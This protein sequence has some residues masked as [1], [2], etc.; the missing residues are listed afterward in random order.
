M[1]FRKIA[2]LIIS[3]VLVFCSADHG[4]AKEKLTLEQFLSAPFPSHL[5][6][7]KKA[8]RI[9]W[10]FLKQGELNV[11]TAAAPDFKPVNLTGFGRNEV[12]EIPSV[13]ITDDGS[14]VVYVR[15]GN[16]NREGWVTN[17]T[18]DPDGVEQAVWAIDVATKKTWKVALGRNPVISPD[19]K[20][21][22]LVK[23]NFIYKVP[24]GEPGQ[25]DKPASPKQLFKAQGQNGSPQWSPDGRK[26]A[27]VSQRED[28]NFIG[29]YDLEKHNITWMAPGVDRDS[30]PLWASDGNKV[31]FFRRPGAE[32]KEFTNPFEVPDAGI[33]IADAETG[34]GREIWKQARDEKPRYYEMRDLYVSAN[35][36]VLFTAEHDNWYH[37]F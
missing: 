34:K 15:G 9:A 35:D 28:H 6:A 22:L 7:A 13:R 32:F 8:D 31:V 36:R 33:W 30:N 18:S 11:W 16:P 1:L 29:V 24:M 12:Y 25:G 10:T 21:I 4:I 2:I 5:V 14:H 27:F 3:L 37:V 17:P 26:I 19:G 20:W 23:G